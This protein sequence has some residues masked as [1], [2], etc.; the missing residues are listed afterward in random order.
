MFIIICWAV[1]PSYPKEI[2]LFIIVY[3]L[4]TY[5]WHLFLSVFLQF[6]FWTTISS[7]GCPVDN[8]WLSIQSPC[9]SLKELLFKFLYQTESYMPSN[10]NLLKLID[11]PQY[12]KRGSSISSPSLLLNLI[13][14]PFHATSATGLLFMDPGSVL[15]TTSVLMLYAV[16]PEVVPS[17]SKFQVRA[18]L[19][20]EPLS[21]IF[22]LIG[23]SS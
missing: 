18:T 1:F 16:M 2:A 21:Y 15:D 11:E 7:I 9:Q 6:P 10:I 14:D 4:F 8:Q 20:R 17:V 12:S 23:M 13:P 19:K 22:L 5:L 3:F